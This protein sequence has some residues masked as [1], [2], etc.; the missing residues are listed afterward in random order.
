MS[1]NKTSWENSPAKVR[2]EYGEDYFKAYQQY[3]HDSHLADASDDISPVVDV[4]EDAVCCRHPMIAYT[5]QLFHYLR[6]WFLLSLP[7][8]VQ[9]YLLL[10][11]PR[12]V[13]DSFKPKFMEVCTKKD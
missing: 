5:P 11:G 9:E 4:L 13:T 12:K 8:N 2:N 1:Q 6:T 7:Y 10:L 3:I